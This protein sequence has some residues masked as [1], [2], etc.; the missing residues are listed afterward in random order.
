MTNFKVITADFINCHISTSKGDSVYSEKRFPKDLTISDLKVKLELMT[1]GSCNTMQVEAYDE[2]N[3]L[4]CKL[5]N[6]NALLGSYPLEDGVRLHV[7]DQFQMRFNT[8]QSELDDVPKFVLPEE[9]YNKRTDTVRSFL[10]KNE[11]GKYNEQNQE[12]KR[13]LEEAEKKMAEDTKVGSRCKVTVQNAATR[14]GTVMYSGTVDGL[15]GYWIGVKYDEPLGK[16]DGSLKGKRYFECPE[17][18]GAF[19]K[20]LNITCGDFPEENYDLNE[21]I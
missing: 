21:E 13:Q 4:I 16:N 2:N 19:V 12:K 8:A 6:N 10:Q 9:E 18:Y 15:S 3:K 1:G 17:K 5:E 11:L 7:I 20:P 14:L